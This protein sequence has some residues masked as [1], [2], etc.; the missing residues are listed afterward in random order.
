MAEEPKQVTR[1]RRLI[2][3][4]QAIELT[5]PQREMYELLKQILEDWEVKH[6]DPRRN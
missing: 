4:M 1:A 5:K 2:A 3:Q 6:R